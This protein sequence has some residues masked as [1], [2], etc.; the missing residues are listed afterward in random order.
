MAQPNAELLQKLEKR[1]SKGEQVFERVA[2]PSSADAGTAMKAAA[3]AQLS[4]EV[5]IKDGASFE[6]ALEKIRA[7]ERRVNSQRQHGGQE[8]SPCTSKAEAS[9]CAGGSQAD[10][11]EQMPST[12][13]REDVKLS[14]KERFLELIAQGLDTNAAAARAILEA[15]KQASDNS[16]PWVQD[17]EDQVAPLQDKATS[18]RSNSPGTRS[19]SSAKS[20]GTRQSCASGARGGS[21]EGKSNKKKAIPVVA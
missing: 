10:T 20:T 11:S 13:R 12:D 8:K 19:N 15:A 17:G 6:A 3:L 14:V 9:G 1:R 7:F 2:E 18:E 16:T 21:A 4:E 5:R